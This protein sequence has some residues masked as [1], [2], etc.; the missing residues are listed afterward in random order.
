MSDFY[1]PVPLPPIP[2]DLSI[3]QFILSLNPTDR[4]SRPSNVPFFIDDDTGKTADYSAVHYRTY[5][6]AN[7]LCN[8][9]R[10]Q[11]GDVVCLLSPNHIDYPV[12]VWAVHVLSAIV[13]PANPGYTP[14]ELAHQLETTKATVVVSHSLCY[15]LACDA[16]RT[17][18]IT[19]DRIIILDKPFIHASI[20]T[21]TLNE[22]ISVGASQ[23]EGYSARRFSPGEARR[24]I[25][26]LSFSSGTTGKPKAV[27]VS[28][29]SI[30][31]NV[32]QMAAHYKINDRSWPDK[33]M[34]P[35]DVVLA[36]LPF[37]H[38]YGLVVIL[39]YSLFC[40]M[41]L[42]V[43]PHFKFSKYMNA[44]IQYRITHLYV[45]PPQ[46][47]L[48]CKRRSEYRMV[49]DRVK[50]CMC[51]A[52][53][54]GGELMKQLAE[55]LPNAAIGQGYGM[56]E[57]CTSISMISPLQK[58]GTI[59]SAG[60]LIPGIRARVLKPDGSLCTDGEQG[61]L[62]VTGPSVAQR[63]FNNDS[64]TKETFLNGWVRTGDEVIIRGL[65]VFVVDRLKEIIKV[66]G[67]QVAP[68]E[69]EGILL[70]HPD[71]IDACVVGVPD[72]YSGE[73]PLAF[74]VPHPRVTEQLSSSGKDIISLKR[75]I[76]E[77]LARATVSYK[78]L[79]GGIEFIDAI[80]KNP[81]GKILRRVL[82]ERAKAY[83]STIS[84]K[85]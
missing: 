68:A 7:A 58:T 1:S 70:L 17:V 62:V 85:L 43:V 80:P 79:S 56:T 78:W 4:P 59:G 3:P 72:D 13:T 57:T 28:H 61:E 74:I 8:N 75:S 52:A 65:E 76:S 2:D 45:V 73:V 39:H 16:A 23:P 19:E 37:F 49:F 38:I 29:Y 36:A 22:L 21:L 41:T 83:R 30:I 69:L 53:P 66:R 84:V 48:L 47:V 27:E 31:A 14:E 50:F 34:N 82:R 40:G 9:Y 20:T 64:A 11:S 25:A 18:G 63:Y 32:M 81:S 10:I 46:V 5:G 6:L 24:T 60:V 54:L 77:H 26:F 51:G 67:F 44:I 15:K 71:V 42:V 55:I 12:V 33:R 35:G